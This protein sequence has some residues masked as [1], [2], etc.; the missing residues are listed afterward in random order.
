MVLMELWGSPQVSGS[1]RIFLLL[2]LCL[3]FLSLA[4]VIYW[5][6]RHWH[7]HPISRALQAH[8]RAPN[9]SWGAMASSINTEFRRIDKFATGVPGASVI[10]TDSWVLKVSAPLQVCRA[11]C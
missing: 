5:S 7:N 8:A 4:L 1:W 10:V 6:R 3:H 2:S 9:S 11:A